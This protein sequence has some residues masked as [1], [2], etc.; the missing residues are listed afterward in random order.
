MNKFITKIAALSVGLAMAIGVGVAV[1]GR[2]AV[3]AKAT[4]YEVLDPITSV[5]DLA[6]GTYV[7]TVTI[8]NVEKYLKFSTMGDYIPLQNVNSTDL[9]TLT[10]E[11]IKLKCVKVNNND[12]WA[13]CYTKNSE[14]YYVGWNTSAKFGTT[15]TVRT[16]A[17]RPLLL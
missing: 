2:E 12:K 9:S 8:S 17:H 4:T 1:G 5:G 16:F 15:K 3:R 7:A 13:F 14:D 10:T 11:F 6:E